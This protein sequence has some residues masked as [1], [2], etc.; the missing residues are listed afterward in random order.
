MSTWG[1]ASPETCPSKTPTDTTC[2]HT[3]TSAVAEKCDK[4]SV[5]QLGPSVVKGMD[6]P[7]P[8]ISKYIT[9]V[10]RCVAAESKIEIHPTKPPVPKKAESTKGEESSIRSVTSTHKNPATS[11]ESITQVSSSLQSQQGRRFEILMYSGTGVLV[12]LFLV[13]AALCRRGSSQRSY[14]GKYGR[15]APLKK[16]EEFDNP[17]AAALENHEGVE[18]MRK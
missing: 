5:C 9:V 4:A 1:R 6:D 14:A 13:G 11:S 12:L 8:D 3:I 16:E 18:L 15:Y 2:E 10:F 7:C 17:F